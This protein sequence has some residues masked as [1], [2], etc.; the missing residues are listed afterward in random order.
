MAVAPPGLERLWKISQA[1]L[2]AVQASRVERG[3]DGAGI[4]ARHVEA[5]D[6]RPGMTAVEREEARDMLL[7]HGLAGGA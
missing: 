3:A 7:S 1:R 6:D 4:V 2:I 5:A